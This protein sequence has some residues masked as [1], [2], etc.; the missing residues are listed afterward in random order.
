MV[1]LQD[2]MNTF[3]RQTP[4]RKCV[5]IWIYWPLGCIN[6][7]SKIAFRIQ[8]V[9]YWSRLEDSTTHIKRWLSRDLISDTNVDDPARSRL[10]PH[11]LRVAE[12]EYKIMIE[13]EGLE[14]QKSL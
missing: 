9:L 14:T 6:K 12:T 13:V 10:S 4:C 3:H 8:Y 11:S 7:D 2:P 1:G 5:K